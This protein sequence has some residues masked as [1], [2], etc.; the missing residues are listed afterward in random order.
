[1][2]FSAPSLH[3]KK[4][5]FL[6][7]NININIEVQVIFTLLLKVIGTLILITLLKNISLPA[8]SMFSTAVFS[9][10]CFNTVEQLKCKA[11]FHVFLK[12]GIYQV[13]K[14]IRMRRR[15][16]LEQKMT[17]RRTEVEPPRGYAW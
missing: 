5:F 9:S 14:K 15:P 13:N 12:E 16:F 17:I 7:I 6:I 4:N 10:S 1:M 11:N 8:H 3:K 2:P